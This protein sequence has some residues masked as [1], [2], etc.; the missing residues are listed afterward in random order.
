VIKAS[1]GLIE[2]LTVIPLIAMNAYDDSATEVSEEYSV[3]G[4]FITIMRKLGRDAFK[5]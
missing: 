1:S 5:P 4:V 3:A 2:W